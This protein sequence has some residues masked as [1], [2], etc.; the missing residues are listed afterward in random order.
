MVNFLFP[1]SHFL[2]Q[3][4]LND[5]ISPG[6]DVAERRYRPRPHQRIQDLK[7]SG[8]EQIEQAGLSL[9]MATKGEN[10][11]ANPLAAWYRKCNLNRF[12]W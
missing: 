5:D 3:E 10:G 7:S 9:L 1:E 11:D 12:G 2:N 4:I 8:K 6:C